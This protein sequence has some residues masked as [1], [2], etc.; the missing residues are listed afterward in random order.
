MTV[1]PAIGLFTPPVG[2]TLFISS[3]IAGIKIEDTIRALILSYL[4]GLMVLFLISNIP[5]MKIT[6]AVHKIKEN[7]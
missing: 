3:T 7:G 6:L 1:N 4:W 5:A 2:M